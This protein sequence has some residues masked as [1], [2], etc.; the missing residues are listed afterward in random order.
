MART[1]RTAEQRAVYEANWR[2]RLWFARGHC[3]LKLSVCTGTV[4]E[5]HHV[6]PQREA[7]ALGVPVDDSFENLR[8]SCSNC[9][10]QVESLGVQTAAVLGLYSPTPLDPERTPEEAAT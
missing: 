6:W 1:R 7:R 8:A 5:P 4:N 3:E 2:A 10:A 9:N